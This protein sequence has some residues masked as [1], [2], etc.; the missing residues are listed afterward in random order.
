M[1]ALCLPLALDLAQTLLGTLDALANH[2]A[3]QFDLFLARA[4]A[5]TS[6]TSLALKVRPA[7]HQPGTQVLQT[8]QLHLKLAFM[9]SGPLGENLQN[10]QCPVIDRQFQV[11]LQIALLGRTETLVKQYLHGAQ[12][13]RQKL[14]FVGLAATNEER[15]IR[16]LS[17]AGDAGNRR[18][19]GGLSQ[20][21]KFFK[22]F[23][24]IG[25][26]QIDTN[27]YGGNQWSGGGGSIALTG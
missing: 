21:P 7:S 5:H 27:Q 12:L 19:P 1:P 8:R 26:T 6:A 2:P 4:S 23:I 18:Q 11:A 10:Q 13:R 17:L 16:R 15:R 9:T 3:V 24:E 22:V 14:D 20:Q 25:Q